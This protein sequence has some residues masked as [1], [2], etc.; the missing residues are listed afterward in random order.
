MAAWKPDMDQS[1]H[2]PV[3]DDFHLSFWEMHLTRTLPNYRS[4]TATRLD[5]L[6]TYVGLSHKSRQGKLKKKVETVTLANNS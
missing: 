1:S 2:K 4:I 5:A 6:D 3:S